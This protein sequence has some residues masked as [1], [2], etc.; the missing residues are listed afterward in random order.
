ELEL[1]NSAIRRYAGLF[2]A[3]GETLNWGAD[4]GLDALLGTSSERRPRDVLAR[5][6]RLW[7]VN[8]PIASLTHA[9]SHDYGHFARGD[10]AGFHTR[11]IRVTHWPWP[12]PLTASVEGSADDAGPRPAPPVQL[13]VLGGG[14]Q[15]VY[16]LKQTLT[17][18]IYS[19]NTANYFDWLALGYA[20]L[21]FP[22]YAWSDLSPSSLTSLDAFFGTQQGDFRQYVLAL[23]EI[24]SDE[25]KIRTVRDYAN[26]IRR[27][28]WL[29]LADYALWAGFARV[30]GYVVT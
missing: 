29:N 7:F 26:G 6:G 2:A 16:T 30:G 22:L 18:K 27:D 21:D 4:L 3:A 25:L 17:D 14:E 13:P 8:L 11:A 23:A 5:L 15:A 20:A 24:E 1:S 19:A 10:E 28:A 12:I 9:A